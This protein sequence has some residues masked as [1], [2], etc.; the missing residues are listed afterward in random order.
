MARNPHIYSR[1]WQV[2]LPGCLTRNDTL[3]RVVKF[4]TLILRAAK[5]GECRFCVYW[6]KTNTEKPWNWLQR[7]V[8]LF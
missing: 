3:L 7:E 5:M 8:W 1:Q 2:Q 6:R 4:P